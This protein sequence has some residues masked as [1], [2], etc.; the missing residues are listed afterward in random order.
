[1]INRL[2]QKLH[3]RWKEYK[4]SPIRLSNL[5]FRDAS[6]D[7]NYK[8]QRRD[9]VFNE[10]KIYLCICLIWFFVSPLILL[11]DRVGFYFVFTMTAVT[12]ASTLGILLAARS[13]PWIIE[14][15]FP[16]NC[17]MRA[18]AS[19]LFTSRVHEMACVSRIYECSIR[20]H[21][22]MLTLSEAVFFWTKLPLIFIGFVAFTSSLT[23]DRQRLA[24]FKNITCETS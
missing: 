17:T 24:V 4:E 15:I 21:N 11:I 5:S 13:K 23:Y 7:K 10:A 16:I 12:A 19:F 9:K 8:A 18:C 3:T 1:M 2:R 14:W 22:Q 6:L 20:N